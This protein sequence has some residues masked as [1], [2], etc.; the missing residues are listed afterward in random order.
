M[1][2]RIVKMTF[3]EDKCPEFEALF[4]QINEKIAKQPGCIDVKLLKEIN[5]PG[6]YFTISHWDSEESLTAYR[7][8][9]L[10]GEVWPT[11]KSWMSAKAE[12]WST[13]EF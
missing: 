9:D 8:T 13:S 6:V 3:R 11:V 1:L 5:Q 2:T 10:F 4:G 12:A 7:N